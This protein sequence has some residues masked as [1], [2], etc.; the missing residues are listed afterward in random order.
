[1]VSDANQGLYTSVSQ[2]QPTSTVNNY[3]LW[4]LYMTLYCQAL[5]KRDVKSTVNINRRQKS[6]PI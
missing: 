4:R 6:K 2:W 3:Y 1:M 5:A